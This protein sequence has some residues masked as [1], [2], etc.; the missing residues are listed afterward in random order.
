MKH[1]TNFTPSAQVYVPTPAEV[2]A[3]I[4]HEICDEME[5]KDGAK[6]PTRI[7]AIIDRGVARANAGEFQ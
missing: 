3:A 2:K 5:R 1:D 7:F 6:I 4:I